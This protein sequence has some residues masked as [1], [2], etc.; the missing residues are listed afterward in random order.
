MLQSTNSGMSC[1]CE[2]VALFLTIGI[3]QI[4]LKL[5]NFNTSQNSRGLQEFHLNLPSLLIKFVLNYKIVNIYASKYK[6]WYVMLL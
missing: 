3:L 1:Y 5:Q 6:F 2:S 4:L